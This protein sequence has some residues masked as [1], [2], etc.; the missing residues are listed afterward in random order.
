MDSD[1]F[2]P[3]GLFEDD[4]S[5][6][7][8]S[9]INPGAREFRPTEPEPRA[10]RAQS[11]DAPPPAFAGGGLL[12]PSQL[13]AAAAAPRGAGP[14]GLDPRRPRL[15]SAS[16]APGAGLGDRGDAW[17]HHNERMTTAAAA[18]AA[19]VMRSLWCRHASPRSPRPAP[20][21]P[22]ADPRRGRRGSRPGGPAPRGAAAAAPSWLGLSS[23]P[24]AKAGGGASAD[25]ARRARGSGSVGRNSRAPGLMPDM[26]CIDSSSS[27]RPPGMKKSLSIVAARV[28]CEYFTPARTSCPSQLSTF[29]APSARIDDGL[30]AEIN[31]RL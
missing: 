17:R 26:L 14:P 24:P 9:G 4:E 3:G 19:V 27:K 7:S 6:Q 18:A 5:M 23:P 20:G 16:G 11:A 22:D 15:G 29:T 28:R 12:S 2:I 1:F 31:N 21:A 10:R 30:N 13:G 8:M 25:C